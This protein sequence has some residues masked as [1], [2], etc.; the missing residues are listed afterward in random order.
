[1]IDFAPGMRV[2]VR[3]EEWMIKKVETNDMKHHA[4]YCIGVTPL[5]RECE[6]VFLDD[7]YR[8]LPMAE[9]FGIHTILVKSHEQAAADL[10][11]MLRES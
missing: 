10:D 6:S 8:N 4:L 1:M 2:M 5:V 7:T 3:D 9:Y 11:A